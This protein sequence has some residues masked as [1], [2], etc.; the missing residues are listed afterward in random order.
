MCSQCREKMVWEQLSQ[1]ILPMLFYRNN[2]LIILR[3]I[4]LRIFS[5]CLYDDININCSKHLL[6]IF[7]IGIFW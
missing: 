7:G 1:K 6:N 4:I 2:I 3:E 5:E